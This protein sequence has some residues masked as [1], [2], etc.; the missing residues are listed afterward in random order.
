[1]KYPRIHMVDIQI[2]R[3]PSFHI[4]SRDTE[5]FAYHAKY[6]DSPHR[7][8]PCYEP[9]FGNPSQPP[10]VFLATAFSH[11]HSTYVTFWT[12]MFSVE[13]VFFGLSPIWD[14]RERHLM[15]S[16]QLQILLLVWVGSQRDSNPDSQ[17][18]ATNN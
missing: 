8:L 13:T 7:Y 14:S 4:C 2:C 6:P 9:M 12:Y 5:A 1:M 3:L 11:T 18:K 16:I 10:Y 15:D 17:S